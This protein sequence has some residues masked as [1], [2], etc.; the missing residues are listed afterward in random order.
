[1]DPTYNYSAWIGV[2]KAWAPSIK[3]TIYKLF[4]S[5]ILFLPKHAAAMSCS[6]FWLDDQLWHRCLP[7]TTQLLASTSNIKGHGGHCTASTGAWQR[8][9][10]ALSKTCWYNSIIPS[11][12]GTPHGGSGILNKCCN[13]EGNFPNSLLARFKVREAKAAWILNIFKVLPCGGIHY[14]VIQISPAVMTVRTKPTPTWFSLQT[15]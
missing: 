1:M 11:L 8:S 10:F 5:V 3:A 12:P 15:K 13:W 2:A 9:V 14:K 4:L 7:A 6:L